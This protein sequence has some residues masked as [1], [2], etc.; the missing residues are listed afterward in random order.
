MLN[1]KGYTPKMVLREQKMSHSF[2]VV[3]PESMTSVQCIS[4]HAY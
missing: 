1:G 2:S 3:A 4:K